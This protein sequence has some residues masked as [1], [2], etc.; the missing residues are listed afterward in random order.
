MLTKNDLTLIE[1]LVEKLL[2]PIQR[3]LDGHGKKLDGH[4]KK[5]D[6]MDKKFDSIDRKFNGFGSRLNEL[7]D[8]LRVNTG[9]VMKIEEKID[10]ALEL[11]EDV[12]QVRGQVKDHEERISQLEKF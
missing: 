5:F 9:S 10:K 6:L 4:D 7:N 2:K 11:R 3:T 8:K 1:K 12:S